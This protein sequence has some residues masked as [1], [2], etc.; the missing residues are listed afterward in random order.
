MK[1]PKTAFFAGTVFWLAALGGASGSIMYSVTDLGTL[2][3]GSISGGSAI[4][5]SGEVTGSAQTAGGS[6]DAFAYSNGV[7]TDLGAPSGYDSDGT[8][9]NNLGQI[10]GRLSNADGAVHAFLYS[11]GVMT[12]LS[13][14]LGFNSSSANGINNSGTVVG[15]GNS[16]FTYNQGSV[17]ILGVPPGYYQASA[18]AI[19][20]NGIV[21]GTVSNGETVYLPYMYNNGAWTRLGMLPGFSDGFSEA[22]NSRGQIVGYISAGLAGNANAFLYSDGTMTDLGLLP[23]GTHSVAN[24]INDLGEIVG[25]ANNSTAERAFLYANG[26]MVDLNSL[27]SPSSGWDL[28]A[29]TA[30]NN[31]GQITGDGTIG[32]QSHAFILTPVPEPAAA[33]LM[34]A[35]ILAVAGMARTRRYRSQK[36]VKTNKSRLRGFKLWRQSR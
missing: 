29:A 3:G 23:G 21:A 35:G 14:A 28:V 31:A 2:P 20:D 19:N 4:N 7:M 32:G 33:T 17:V 8:G 5:A 26:G 12:D 9:I 22:I 13:A 10:S 1:I 16:S 34:A 25:Q 15:S 36:K 30:I 11:N 24:G 27:I 6:F 18:G